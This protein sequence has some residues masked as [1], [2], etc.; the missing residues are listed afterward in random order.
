MNTKLK[1]EELADKNKKN[2]QLTAKQKLLFTMFCWGMQSWGQANNFKTNG[3][4]QKYKEAKKA[5]H[6]GL[7]I[8]ATGITLFVLLLM[9]FSKN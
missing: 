8:Y 2:Q 9:Y 5:I 1:P 7:S 3:Y 6:I 4:D